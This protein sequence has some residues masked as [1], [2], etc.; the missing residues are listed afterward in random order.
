[1]FVSLDLLVDVYVQLGFRQCTGDPFVFVR[2]DGAQVFHAPFEGMVDLGF[3]IEDIGH[4]DSAL[5][6][7]FRAIVLELLSENLPEGDGS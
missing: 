7:R 2:S 3:V 4:L 1:M 5:S 6:E